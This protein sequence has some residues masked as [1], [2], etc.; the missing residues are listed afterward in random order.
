MLMRPPPRRVEDEVDFIEATEAPPGLCMLLFLLPLLLLGG[1]AFSRPIR[2]IMDTRPLGGR[3]GSPDDEAAVAEDGSMLLRRLLRGA[4]AAE[5]S[6][7]A[8][9]MR[10]GLRGFRGVVLLIFVFASRSVASRRVNSRVLLCYCCSLS[11]SLTKRNRGIAARKVNNQSNSKGLYCTSN[12]AFTIIVCCLVHF[13]GLFLNVVTT[14]EG[15]DRRERTPV[16]KTINS[17]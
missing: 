13:R 6:P 5:G 12:Q 10:R 15:C 2:G 14:F 4:S 8:S 9:V 16:F 1:R 3:L 7:P 11:R 17:S